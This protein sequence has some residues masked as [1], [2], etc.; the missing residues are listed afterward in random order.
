MNGNGHLL[1]LF[2]FSALL[3][4]L[5]TFNRYFKVSSY[6]T[7]KMFHMGIATGMYFSPWLL[8]FRDITPFPYLIL[9]AVMYFSFRFEIF[10]AIEH[11][12][13]SL[14][15]VLLPLLCATLTWWFT[16]EE[17]YI[18]IAA[19]ASA[20]FGDSTAAIVGRRQGTRKYHTYSTVRSMEG[21]LA[22]FFAAGIT[23][24][25]VLAILGDLGWHQSIAFALIAAT[26][27][28]SAEAV[29]PSSIDNL[30]V[31]LSTA[32]TL[33]ALINLSQ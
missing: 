31:P 33:S 21:T 19:I 27:A 6:L 11:S 5:E 12:G 30:T 32:I 10:H 16:N 9:T 23:M 25:P 8:E 28:A 18:A 22:F 26:I 14:G 3:I 24:A 2:Y 4:S 1:L 20:G 13:A 17:F 15:S 29:S 7:R